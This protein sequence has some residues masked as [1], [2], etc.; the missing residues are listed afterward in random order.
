[1][2]CVLTPAGK[3]CS[4]VYPASL[5]HL[6]IFYFI[7]YKQYKLYIQTNFTTSYKLRSW[8]MSLDQIYSS[9]FFLRFTFVQTV[10][11][12]TETISCCCTEVYTWRMDTHTQKKKIVPADCGAERFVCLHSNQCDVVLSI[13][14]TNTWQAFI[15]RRRNLSWWN[16][17]L[18]ITITTASRFQLVFTTQ[19]I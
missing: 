7:D 14:E 9:H 3:I 1:M 10:V 5:S 19:I 17:L 13:N 11:S 18:V 12:V 15:P 6:I 4:L 8:A 16:I 2:L